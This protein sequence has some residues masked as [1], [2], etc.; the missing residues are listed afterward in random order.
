MNRS[1][2]PRMA[3]VSLHCV[4]FPIHARSGIDWYI[5][6]WVERLGTMASGDPV[7]RVEDVHPRD[8]LVERELSSPQHRW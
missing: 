2:D 1:R 4:H 7:V 5:D 8:D 6:T 3:H